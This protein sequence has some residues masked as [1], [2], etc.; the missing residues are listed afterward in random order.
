MV[1]IHRQA[2]SCLLVLSIMLLA[3]AHCAEGLSSNSGDGVISRRRALVQGAGAAAAFSFAS[4]ASAATKTSIVSRL[5]SAAKLSMPSPTNVGSELNGVDN[6]Y[7]PT[8]MTGDWSV[9]QTLVGADTP[10]GLKFVGGPNASEKIATETMTEARKRIGIPVELKLRFVPTKW[11]VAEDRLYNTRQR[12]D[13]FAGKSVVAAVDY[14][15]VNASNR[16]A[17]LAKGGTEE[18]PLQTTFVRFKGPAAQ[19]TFVVSHGTEKLSDTEW[20]G[21]ELNRS[22]FALTNQSTAPPLTTDSELIWE[23]E[24]LDDNHVKAKLRI[25]G[26]LNPQSDTLY[27]D[28]RQRAVILQDYTLDFRK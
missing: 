24:K 8:W 5:D 26:Y 13:A 3:A 16:N 28:A 9:S 11:G 22:I 17:V 23:M 2:A 6:L 20:A 7:F 27:F 12:L 10:L 15:N 25:A 21:Y 14:S 1:Q 4:A 19:K 18:D